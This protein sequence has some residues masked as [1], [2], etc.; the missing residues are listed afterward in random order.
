MAFRENGKTVLRP[1][2][3]EDM[4]MDLDTLPMP[5]WELLPN[6]RYWEVGRPHGAASDSGDPFRYASMMTSLGCVFKCS[7]CH[8]SGE[9]EGSIFG[10]IGKFRVKSEARVIDEF[11]KLKSLGVEHL[12]LEDDTLFGMKR[13][14]IDLLRKVKS[15]GFHMWDING[16]NIAHLAPSKNQYSNKHKMTLK[17]FYFFTLNM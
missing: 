1:T 16:I 17:I 7:Y 3:I 6:E 14:G 12:F 10:P 4:V 9:Q 13:R 5:S 2:Q 8:I 11:E 15:F